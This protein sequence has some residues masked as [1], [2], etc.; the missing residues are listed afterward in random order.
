[1][2]AARAAGHILRERF[3]KPHDVS[4]KGLRD[5]VTEADFLAQEAIVAEIRTRFPTDQIL[6]E[7]ADRALGAESPRRWFVDPLDGTTNFARGIP[8]FSVSIA[9]ASDGEL[10]VAVVY[11]PLGDRLFQAVRGEGAYLD[12]Q[13]LQ[14]S[15]RSRLIDTLLDLGWARSPAA[16]DTSSRV[17]RAVGPHIGSARTMGSAALGLAAVAA[18]WEDAFYHP[19]LAPWDMAAGA[20]LVREAGGTV[21]AGDGSPW[22]AFG[23]TCLASNGLLHH[24]LV[25]LIAPE[26]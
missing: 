6:T 15:E 14:V 12:G 21:T 8:Y 3:A 7:E 25:Q 24:A 1:M 20:L 17:A 13:R 26:M 9:A 4:C 2:A 23:R 19:E 22:D 18:G 5:V 11:E 10:L 16:R